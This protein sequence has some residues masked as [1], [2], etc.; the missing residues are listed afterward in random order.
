MLLFLYITRKIVKE[1]KA[2]ILELLGDVLDT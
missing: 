1:M 2:K